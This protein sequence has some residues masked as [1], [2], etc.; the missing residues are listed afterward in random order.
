MAASAC[1]ICMGLAATHHNQTA[2]QLSAEYKL[3]LGCC[4]SM[5]NYINKRHL[6]NSRPPQ[7]AAIR[8]RSRGHI[9]QPSSEAED[10]YVLVLFGA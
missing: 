5:Q 6:M 3:N 7:M 8:P 4:L 2:V 1:Q 10:L 9:L